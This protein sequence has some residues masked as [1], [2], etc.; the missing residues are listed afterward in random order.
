MGKYKTTPMLLG[1]ERKKYVCE[2]CGDRFFAPR[3][4]KYCSR[5]C[6]SDAMRKP[7]DED[8]AISLYKSGYSMKQVATEVGV[9]VPTVRLLLW[10]NDIE[11]RGN[12]KR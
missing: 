3:K 8:K 4:K 2:L 9:S 12:R 10:S 11:I 5:E 1:D 6:H 7:F